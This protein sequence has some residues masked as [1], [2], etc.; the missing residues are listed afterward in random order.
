MGFSTCLSPYYCLQDHPPA[1]SAKCALL[2]EDASPRDI[3]DTLA[4]MKA[5]KVS[6][7]NPDVMVL[8]CDQVL[9]LEGQLLS[10]PQSSEDAVT[11]L[12][13]MQEKRQMLLSAAVIYQNGE[14][15]WWHVGQVRMRGQLRCLSA[16]LC[17]PQLGQYP[18]RGL[19]L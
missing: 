3:A 13:M 5:R 7:K 8:G 6:D 12:K 14:P 9:D 15:I 4:G 11:Q 18:P 19:G 17:R 16:R 1:R 10:K 2:A